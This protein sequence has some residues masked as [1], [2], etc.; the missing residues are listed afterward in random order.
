MKNNLQKIVLWIPYI[1]YPLINILVSRIVSLPAWTTTWIDIAWL[2]LF[3]VA[4]LIF[5]IKLSRKAHQRITYLILF[6][7]FFIAAMMLIRFWSLFD[8]SLSASV[9]PYAMEVQPVFFALLVILWIYT[10][11]PPAKTAFINAGAGLGTILISQFVVESLIAGRIVRISGS[12]DVNYDAVLL[13]IAY[14]LSLE[15]ERQQPFKLLL[16][17]V[18]FVATFSRT[19]MA[20]AMINV[21][22]FGR[23]KW[24]YKAVFLGV[25]LLAI[26]VSFQIRDIPFRVFSADRFWMWKSAFELFQSQPWQALLGFSIGHPLPVF[27]PQALNWLWETQRQSWGL[28]GI[29]PYNFHAFWLR[30]AISWGIPVALLI[31]SLFAVVFI[32]THSRSLRSLIVTCVV[33]G[34]TMGLFYISNVS[35]PI[36][37][38][39]FVCKDVHNR[40]K[41]F[42]YPMTNSLLEKA[43]SSRLSG[44]LGFQERGNG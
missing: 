12:G 34:V 25:A 20:I 2:G 28:P 29:Y 41:S 7:L 39:F 35:I 11:G 30:I 15:E 18:G 19:G 32:R 23:H 36:L 26:I 14:A 33:S 6:A 22:L 37:L 13:L 24:I 8:Y 16:I 31:L 1:A 42:A 21:L 9:V 3:F 5:I 4:L 40:K 27:T 43:S 38:A 44:S 10:F 17:M